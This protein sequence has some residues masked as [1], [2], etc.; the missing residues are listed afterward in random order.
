M[1]LRHHKHLYKRE[2]GRGAR[3]REGMTEAEVRAR[4]SYEAATLLALRAEEGA[5][6]QGGQAAFRNGK[7]K[8]RSSDDP[9]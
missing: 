4:R 5:L 9:L 2:E 3:E 6:S 7:G 1:A 8:E